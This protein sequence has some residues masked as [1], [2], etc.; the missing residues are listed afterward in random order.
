MEKR[1]QKV[2]TLVI[3]QVR[4]EEIGVGDQDMRKIQGGRY[5]NHRQKF[6]VWLMAGHTVLSSAEA[7]SF[8]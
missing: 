4:N 6:G 3:P 5:Q 2:S 8:C 1:G 7:E